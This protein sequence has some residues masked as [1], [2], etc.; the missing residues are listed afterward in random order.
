MMRDRDDFDDN[1]DIEDSGV[2]NNEVTQ[3]QQNNAEQDKIYKAI[4]LKYT[5][6]LND[7]DNL[8]RRSTEEKEAAYEKGE[9]E[10]IKK[11]LGILDDFERAIK[12]NEK[13]DNPKILKDGFILIYDK[14]VK[15]LSQL[16]VERIVTNGHKFNPDFH[17]AVAT[18]PT[19]NFARPQDAG[20]IY[21]TMFNG[22]ARKNKVL[23]HA[24]VVVLKRD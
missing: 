11:F 4:S 20:K 2:E 16:G 24:K 22:Y 17:E 7:F 1:F 3:Q 12:E 8:K 23:K 10:V 6:L 14:F 15:E 21:D 18:L 13:T 9:N 19:T 5:E